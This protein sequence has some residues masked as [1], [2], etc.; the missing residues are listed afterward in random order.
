MTNQT[1]DDAYRFAM[2]GRPTKAAEGT[3]E[4]TPGGE[5]PVTWVSVAAALGPAHAEILR[6][7]LETEGI[8]ALV[9]RE[10]AGSAYGL[11][12]GLLG[13]VDIVVPQEYAARAREIL[14]DVG[15]ETGE[16]EEA[17]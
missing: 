16:D 10:P 6:G 17:R 9:V 4:G 15:E 11:T 13:Q 3:S 5:E 14:A 2:P 8:P 7:R 1:W 12:V